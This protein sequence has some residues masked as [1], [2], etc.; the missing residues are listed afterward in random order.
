[1]ILYAMQCVIGMCTIQTCVVSNHSP[2]LAFKTPASLWLEQT[3]EAH[4]LRCCLACL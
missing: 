2:L 1:M 4:L 3:S